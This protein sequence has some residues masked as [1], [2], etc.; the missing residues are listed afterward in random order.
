MKPDRT[1]PDGTV[2]RYE[3]APRGSR[4]GTPW[5]GSK[6]EWAW[7]PY[8]PDKTA[9]PSPGSISSRVRAWTAKA[10]ELGRIT[11]KDA[12]ALELCAM[13]MESDGT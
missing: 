8:I 12:A 5:E 2:L 3:Q 7:V 13:E 11:R 6:L 9:T 4:R 1:L 10:T